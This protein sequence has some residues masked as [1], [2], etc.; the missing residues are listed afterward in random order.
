M[1]TLPTINNAGPRMPD[2]DFGK[3][4]REKEKSCYFISDNRVS[5]QH[6]NKYLDL[7]IVYQLLLL[8]KDNFNLILLTKACASYL[9]YNKSICH[10]ILY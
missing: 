9:L 10:Y 7:S 8:I 2:E 5:S 1:A 3:S 6:W 4:A